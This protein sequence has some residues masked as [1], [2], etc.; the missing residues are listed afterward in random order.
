MLTYLLFI[1]F[2]YTIFLHFN[3][4]TVFYRVTNK[5]IILIRIGTNTKYFYLYLGYK[6]LYVFKLYF[7]N[8]YNFIALVFFKY[9]K[10]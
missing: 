7:S 2:I 6:N 9:S 3:R 5:K 4:K 1:S 8:G 10:N